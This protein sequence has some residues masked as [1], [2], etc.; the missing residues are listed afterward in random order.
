MTK[1]N[2]KLGSLCLYVFCVLYLFSSIVSAAGVY[3][4]CF[5]LDCPFVGSVYENTEIS[6]NGILYN[7]VSFVF[8]IRNNDPNMSI[9]R[10][11]YNNTKQIILDTDEFI[12][13]NEINS[14]ISNVSFSVY[15]M[16]IFNTSSGYYEQPTNITNLFSLVAD[17]S[18]GA[19][20]HKLILT[21]PA[22]FEH[23]NEYTD[24]IFVTISYKTTKSVLQE[25]DKFEVLPLLPISPQ[26]YYAATP[27]LHWNSQNTEIQRTIILPPRT[28]PVSYP[29]DLRLVVLP[30][31]PFRYAFTFESHDKT[32]AS[33]QQIIFVYSDTEEFWKPLKWAVLGAIA[34][35]LLFKLDE[36][37]RRSKHGGEK[38]AE[39]TEHDFYDIA[40]ENLAEISRREILDAYFAQRSISPVK[41]S[42]VFTVFVTVFVF[43]SQ[44]LLDSVKTGDI[45]TLVGYLVGLLVISWIFFPRVSNFIIEDKAYSQKLLGLYEKKFSLPRPEKQTARKNAKQ[46]RDSH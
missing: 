20:V 22:T 21:L 5:P 40:K 29:Q 41:F 1:T 26:S 44:V 31:T 16:Q 28:K 8:S 37:L 33:L 42:I 3:L 6:E 32:Y 35:Y 24:P 19:G 4:D 17:S 18:R 36:L 9:D 39:Q 11:Y 43:F 10:S 45:I 7:Q 12:P 46:N 15:G 27:R 13:A 34:G 30:T 2:L 23:P 14:T 38:M 25:L